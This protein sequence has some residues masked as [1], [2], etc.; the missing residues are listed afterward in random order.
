MS[1]LTE[2]PLGLPGNIYRSPMPFGPYDS[3]GIIFEAYKSHHVAVVVV[4]A[5]DDE[6]L[7]KAKR[8]LPAFYTREGLDVIHCPIR[9]FTAPSFTD[10]QTGLSQTI[11]HAKYGRNVAIHCSAGIG[12]TG[13]FA[14]LLARAL[15]G[16]S[17]EEA[18]QWVR[19]YIEGAVETTE[20]RQ[21]VISATV[22]SPKQE[23]S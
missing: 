16:L 7:Q 17:G 4:L 19:R 21:F 8:N 9:D 5:E 3:A 22:A 20:Q 2:L 18:I 11:S 12:R 1:S 10:L 15:L 6:C 13:L 14:A 23:A